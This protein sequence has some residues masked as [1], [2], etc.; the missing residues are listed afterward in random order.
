MIAYIVPAR[1]ADTTGLMRYLFGPG[2]HNEHV[3]QRVIAASDPLGV[4]DGTRLRHEEDQEEIRALGEELDSH[5]KA[6]GVTMSGGHV[7]HCAISIPREDRALTDEEWAQVARTAVRELGFTEASGRAACRWVAV[8][9]GPSAEGNDHLHL[10]VNLVRE[11]GTRALTWK[12][13]RTMSRVCSHFERKFGL[14]RVE[15]RAGAG[16]PGLSRAEIARAARVGGESERVRLARIV[17]GCAVAAGGEAE[18]VR[19]LRSSVVFVRP[20]FAKGGRRE[21]V[22]YSVALRPRYGRALVWFGGG[23][24]AGDLTLPRLREHWRTSPASRAEAVAEWSRVRSGRPP[25]RNEGYRSESWAQAAAA[26]DR[27]RGELAAAAVDDSAVWAGAAREA[28]GVLAAWS[29]RLETRHPGPLA[30]AADALARSA[31]TPIEEPRARRTGRVRDLRGVAMVAWAA[32]GT[33]SEVL[34]MQQIIRLVETIGEMHQARGQARQAAALADA[35]RAGLVSIQRQRTQA[36]LNPHP[37]GADP[38]SARPTTPPPSSGPRP[39]PD[40]GR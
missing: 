28:A 13:R 29:T 9:H 22:G 5:R 25:H 39:G 8:H 26:V 6:M 14:T 2:R 27:V 31:Q 19:R 16:L 1:G 7:W 18:F 36:A 32:S 30:A 34:L 23:R 4:A 37:R 35:A 17:R 38:R 33:M 24:L 12:D 40:I 11:D 20:R 10:V 21:V 15:G 3:D